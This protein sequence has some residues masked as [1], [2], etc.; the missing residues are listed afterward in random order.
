[1]KSII[2][3]ITG[4]LLAVAASGPAT[5][6]EP[7]SGCVAPSFTYDIESTIKACTALLK[8]PA[9]PAAERAKILTLRGRS[10]RNAGQFDAAI[11]DL[12]LALAFTPND[13]TALE[14]RA[15]A[16]IDEGDLETADAIAR[17]MLAADG[18]D[19]VAYDL[20]GIVAF[21][22]NDYGAADRLYSKAIALRPNYILPWFIRLLL[23]KTAGDHR[24]VIAQANAILALKTPELDTLYSTVGKKRMTFRT[25]TRLERVVA[26]EGLGSTEDIE[27]AFAHWIAV[28]PDAVSYGY[29]ARFYARREQND[30]AL[31]DVA[32]ALADDPKFWLLYYT[33]G[34]VY[35]YSNHD[36]E[37]VASFTQAIALNPDA[38]AAYWLRAMAERK[39]HRDDAALRDALKAV[40]VDRPFRD[41]KIAV[42]AK[43][44]YLQIGPSDLKNPLPAIADAVHACMLDDRCW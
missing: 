35:L 41:D 14:M 25:Q 20:S 2:L 28:E 3:L 38:G 43:L 19:A 11:K 17:K 10:L 40:A 9:L 30:K 37:A 26:Y 13:H 12:D 8:D 7:A 42:L 4:C 33:R 27:K 6:S 5:A 15:G 31:D 39:L 32:K 24:G 18:K 1:V 36:E 34:D 23:Y 21:G 44:G 29:R 22:R 16:A